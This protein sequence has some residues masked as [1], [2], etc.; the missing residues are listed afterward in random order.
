MAIMTEWYL[1][2]A[3]I[4][5][6]LVM[7]IA[8]RTDARR[9]EEALAE[10]TAEFERKMAALQARNGELTAENDRLT[11]F[12]G[13]RDIVAEVARLRAE[14]DAA[15]EAARREARSIV[16]DAQTALEAAQSQAG[17]IRMAALEEARKIRQ[18]AQTEADAIRH[19]A[20]IRSSVTIGRADTRAQ[21]LTAQAET[22]IA[23]A[24]ERAAKLVSDA[25]VRAREIAGDAY[26]ALS[27]AEQ[28][29]RTA[30]A[31]R[32][33]IQGYGDRYLK[34][35]YSLLDELADDYGFDEAG[36]EL[37]RARAN[38]QSLIEA[39]RA[40]T[41]DYV[42]R[43]RR[44]TAIRFVLD[45]FNGKVDTILGRV[46]SDNFGTLEQQIRDAFSLVN[47]NGSA[48][49]EARI[50]PEYLASRLEELRWAASAMALR[51]R[52]KE[53]QRRMREQI[54]E[55]EKAR[56]EIERA[57]RDAAKEEDSLR[58]AMAKVQAQVAR[59]NEEQ[60]VAY[61]AQVLELQA[62]LAEAEARNQ[63]ALS[64]AQQTKAGHVYVIS[65]IGS[66]GEHVFKVGMTRRLE[67]LDR[68]RELGDA[69]V[70][71]PFDVHAMIWA[72]DA[73][74]LEATLHKHFVTAQVNKVN[75]RKE[76]FRVPLRSL[77]QVVED[78]GLQTTWTITAAAA[79]YRET[80]AIESALADETDEGRSWLK[81]Q[82]EVTAED[83]AAATDVDDDELQTA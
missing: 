79:Q 30:A 66:F 83:L 21:A 55:E 16:S 1:V 64:M 9:A 73:P 20:K 45:A 68:V 82:L 44:E 81:K 31:M 29:E 26:R 4:L 34:P 51:E 76:F 36:R 5:A 54:R 59:A 71:F 18:S 24:N 25:E 22:L 17:T 50:T 12:S 63:R 61:E 60:R 69:S 37:K 56:R 49:R 46:K 35:T 77:Q 13:V 62:R 70:P 40:A 67:P 7:Y 14:G 39:D 38:S 57:L 10:A 19:E 11:P 75:P 41:C 74:A 27:Q 53:E 15:V 28:L 52:D 2:G 42:E 33:V 23:E 72:D 3:C 80:L 32:N 47:H 48:F 43:H 78:Q 58:K 65:N 8:K 6:L